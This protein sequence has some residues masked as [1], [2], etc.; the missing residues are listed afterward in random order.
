[1]LELI[2]VI[3]V[4]GILLYCVNQFVPMDPKIKNILNIVVVVCLVFYVL[5]AFGLFRHLHSVPVPQ[6]R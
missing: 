2:L 5:G 4:I 6:I 1:M 3:I